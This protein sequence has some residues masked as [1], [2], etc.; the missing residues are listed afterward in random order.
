MH[1]KIEV[2][3]GGSTDDL[4]EFMDIRIL[5]HLAAFVTFAGAA[6]ICLRCVVVSGQLCHRALME[7]AVNQAYVGTCTFVTQNGS[8]F[9]Y[10]SGRYACTV[11][12]NRESIT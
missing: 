11:D 5:V 2:Q 6:C 7:P 4:H 3:H 12:D 9:K 10:A 8:Q 1:L